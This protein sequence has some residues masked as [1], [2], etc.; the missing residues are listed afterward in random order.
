MGLQPHVIRH[1]AGIANSVNPCAAAEGSMEIA[2][3]VV[4][5]SRDVVEPRRG[6]SQTAALAGGAIPNALSFK[7]GKIL[8]LSYTTTNLAGGMSSYDPATDAWTA[9]TSNL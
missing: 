2:D 3:N 1:F 8:A 7:D 4:I 6:Y 9:L 5:R